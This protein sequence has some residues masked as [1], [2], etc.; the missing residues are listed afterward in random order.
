M[1]QSKPSDIRLGRLELQIMNAVWERG[2]ATVQEVKD[3]LS[4]DP[5][6]KPAYTT[7]L[8]MMRKLEIKGYLTHE[9][10]RRTFIYLPAVSRRRVRKTLLGD[11]LDRLFE[12]SP[13]LL[14]NNLVS[15]QKISDQDLTE[16]R[17]LVGKTKKENSKA[18]K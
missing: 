18:E 7:I 6:K 11:L 13:A 16:I 8:T 9:L 2:R 12:G 14:V 4:V 3:A 17:K 15:E 5:A 10:S 1:T